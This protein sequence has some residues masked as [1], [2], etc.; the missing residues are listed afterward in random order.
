MAV[1]QGA[2]AGHP[3][4]FWQSCV[5]CQS[6]RDKHPGALSTVLNGG[7]RR[8]GG[9]GEA[10]EGK[11]VSTGNDCVPCFTVITHVYSRVL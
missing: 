11:R 1:D 7:R 2:H 8:C 4:T 9:E 6:P 3:R 5:P 10:G